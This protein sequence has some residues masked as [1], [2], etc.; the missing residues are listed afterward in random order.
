MVYGS[1]MSMNTK[2]YTPS[3][4]L[5]LRPALKTFIK[6]QV[7]SGQFR[8][9]N[10]VINVAVERLRIGRESLVKRRSTPRSIWLKPVVVTDRSFLE[11]E[12]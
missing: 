12:N 4:G 7:T 9:E 10:E 2:S 6:K 3:S 5:I 11:K 8:S 1:L